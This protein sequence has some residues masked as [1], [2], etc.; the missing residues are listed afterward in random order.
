[1]NLKR[2]ILILFKKPFIIYP[3]FNDLLRSISI[4]FDYNFGKGKSFN[5]KTLTINVTK[6]CNLNCKMCQFAHSNLDKVK[7]NNLSR[8]EKNMLDLKIL[9]KLLSN[10][11]GSKPYIALTGGE[12]TLHPQIEKII[13]L[14]KKYGFYVS[15]VTNGALLQ[16][17]A[18]KIISSGLD[19][20]SISI[21]GLEKTHDSIRRVPN[22]FQKAV[23]GI[24]KIIE[25]KTNKKLKKPIVILNTS[26]SNE[27]IHELNDIA[28]LAK[29]LNVDAINFQ[30]LWMQT[31]KM[32]QNFNKTFPKINLSESYDLDL[33]T[34]QINP[35]VLYENLQKIKKI[36]P[37]VN[38]F[39]DLSIEKIKDYYK[40]PESFII[41]KN[42]YC[43]WFFCTIQPDGRVTMCKEI[44]MGNLNELDFGQIWNSEKFKTFR[45]KIKK[46]KHFPICSRCCLYFRDY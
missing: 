2:N 12:T 1:M 16:E 17:K 27:N 18:E 9:E 31:S 7:L 15:M 14:I 21:D 38:I 6:I 40:N 41:D 43:P 42:C 26:L 30:H 23:S 32:T 33:N 11:K 25:I 5:P 8:K 24:K 22:T 19:M 20:L 45:R 37:F 4:N 13:S 3:L 10:W 39:P 36:H 46:Y 29:N 28:K 34:N 44:E 35:I